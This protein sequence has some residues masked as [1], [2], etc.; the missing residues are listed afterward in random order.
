MARILPE[1]PVGAK[2]TSCRSRGTIRLPQHHSIFCSDC[3]LRF[4]RTA[5]TRAMKNFGLPANTPF[6]VAVSGG[7]DSLA[8]WDVLHDLGYQTKGLH[9]ELGIDGFSEAS[10]EAV[11]TF[12]QER[13]LPWID[14]PLKTALGYDLYEIRRL[15]RRKMCSVCGL[16]K[17]QLLNRLTIREGFGALAVGHNLDDEAGRLL[18][19]IVRHRNRYLKKQSPFL[20]STHPRM[21]AKLK[22]LYRLEASE[23]LT[24]CNLKSIRYVAL[25]CPLSRGAT[26]HYF[27]EAL[28]LLESRMPSTKRDF[29][30][31][32]LDRN[33]PHP[34]E[35][36][37]LTCTRCG[38][39]TYAQLCSVCNLLAKVESG[40]LPEST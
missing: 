2:C 30:F 16:L 17:R 37:F 22:P 4:F 36:P 21:P 24:Y 13:N 38:E 23:I 20:P 6:L 1:L 27:K 40:R 34:E 32:Y 10:M 33:Q 11:G 26:S 18:G 35:K 3:F 39:P 29:L 19:N 7:K 31:T 15:T 25:R 12:A 8:L 9:L 28:D 14:Y 5:V